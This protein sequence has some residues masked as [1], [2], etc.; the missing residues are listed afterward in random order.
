MCGHSA[1]FQ[2]RTGLSVGFRHA[3]RGLKR[4]VLLGTTGADLGGINF[5]LLYHRV[6]PLTGARQTVKVGGGG[7]GDPRTFSVAG[8]GF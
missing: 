3:G 8:R 5:R 4:M 6:G 2:G 1:T 7:D